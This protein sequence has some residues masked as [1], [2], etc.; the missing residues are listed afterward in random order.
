HRFAAPARPELDGDAPGGAQR[1]RGGRRL[2][3]VPT[4][5][6]TEGD[7]LD[8]SART[9]PRTCQRGRRVLLPRHRPERPLPSGRDPHAHPGLSLRSAPHESKEMVMKISTR[10]GGVAAALMAAALAVTG[11]TTTSQSGGDV[12]AV[13]QELTY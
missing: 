8:L 9:G 11:C 1:F 12:G 5:L 13:P 7:R 10:H 2:S 6:A 3:P 4:G